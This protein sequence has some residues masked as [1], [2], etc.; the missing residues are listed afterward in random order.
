MQSDYNFIDD[1]KG[2]AASGKINLTSWEDD[3]LDSIEERLDED[4][5]LT[6]KQRETL[7]RIHTRIPAW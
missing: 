6:R 4:R 1:I 5:E 7:D 3:F 2:A